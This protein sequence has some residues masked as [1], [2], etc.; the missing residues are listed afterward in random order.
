[1]EP[2]NG[3]VEA[4]AEEQGGLVT[5]ERHVFKVPAP[6][7]S[8]LGEVWVA[9]SCWLVGDACS[10][11][12]DHQKWQCEHLKAMWNSKKWV[13][14]HARRKSSSVQGSGCVSASSMPRH[15]ASAQPRV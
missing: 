12:L 3:Q 9:G 14:Q 10:R 15:V 7:S 2:P 4:S 1:M 13:E 11:C 8:L 5:R 6:K